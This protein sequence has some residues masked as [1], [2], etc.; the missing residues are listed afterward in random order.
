MGG[1]GEQDPLAELSLG[2]F[3]DRLARRTSMP[4]GGVVCA[5]Q[6]AQ[7]AALV[8]MAAK[9]SSAEDSGSLTEL[10]ADSD[11]LV[12]EALRLAEEDQ[13][14]YAGVKAAYSL[15]STRPD[16]QD[17]LAQALVEASGPP[18]GV[19]SL[20]GQVVTLAER[21]LPVLNPM[22]E[23]DLA[24]AADVAHAAASGARS[25]IEANLR[26]LNHGDGAEP[27]LASLDDVDPILERARAVRESLR[28]KNA[29]EP[30]HPT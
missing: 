5:L 20:A 17:L 29:S 11:R 15:P 2:Q 8:A 16:R 4:A 30:A 12:T 14:V 7:A 21:L 25:T 13:R 1:L 9:F 27:V 10:A 19:V 3:L 18:A 6:A 28:R 23:A 22:L 26:W 24:V